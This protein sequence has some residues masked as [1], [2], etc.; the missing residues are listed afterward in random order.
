MKKLL[1][2]ISVFIFMSALNAKVK[3]PIVCKLPSPT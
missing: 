2:L 3:S 1:T